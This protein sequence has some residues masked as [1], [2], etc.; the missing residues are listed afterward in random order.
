M[1]DE[2]FAT[3]D[4]PGAIYTAVNGISANGRLT[5]TYIDSSRSHAF[6]LSKG[7]FTT[8]DPPGSIQSQGGFL[9]AQGTAVGGYRDVNGKRHAFL[10]SKG[11]FT[12]IDPP[13]G[14]RR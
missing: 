14:T 5:G 1:A 10:W 12:T 2:A 3:V 4:V 6:L 7:V 11:V 9:N 8:L 13:M